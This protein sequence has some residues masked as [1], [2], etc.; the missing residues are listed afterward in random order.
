[1]LQ[2]MAALRLAETLLPMTEKG[3]K[4]SSL[5]EIKIDDKPAVGIKAAR[6]GL[7][8]MDLYFDKVTMLP[9][10][11]EM[12]LQETDSMEATYVA[13]FGA[14][15]KVKGRQFFTKLTVLRDDKVLLEMERS[16]FEAKENVDD[17]TFGKP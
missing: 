6:K 4:L 2:G 7:P 12:R 5:G 9:M 1:F 13:R 8:E 10:K 17:E 15:K 11:A 3:W 16:D 14:Y